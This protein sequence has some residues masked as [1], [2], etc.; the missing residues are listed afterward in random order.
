MKQGCTDKGFEA[1]KPIIILLILWIILLLAGICR[2]EVLDELLN[3]I[4]VIES[5]NNP[6]AYNKAEDAAGLYQIRP[7][8]LAD[9]NRILGCDRYSLADRFDPEK[10]SEIVTVYLN[11]YGRDKNVETLARIHNG[12]P[13]GHKKESTK[14]YWQKVK[15]K[16]GN[17]IFNAP[18]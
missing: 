1:A 4:A 15:E 18:K 7:I 13:K 12:G 10:S 5:S 11:H 9:V 16:L 17:D 6:T 3:A 8:Y 2:G 14:P